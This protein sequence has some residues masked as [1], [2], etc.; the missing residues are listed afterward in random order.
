[1]DTKYCDLIGLNDYFQPAY[2]L[3]NEVQN[4]WKQFIPNAKFFEVL[5]GVLSSCEG[6]QPAEKKSLWL[7]GT[8][9]TGKS[10][11]TSVL[12]HLLF[13]EYTEI[14]P[15]VTTH[16]DDV[17]LK[18][19]LLNFRR[20]NR[21]FPV[22]LKGVSGIADHRTFA[23]VLERAVKHALTHYAI[24][25]STKSDFEK[26]ISK[27]EENPYHSDWDQVIKRYPQLRMYVKDQADLIRK[28]K[29][30]DLKILKIL[31][32]LSSVTGIHFSHANITDWLVEVGTELRQ[33]QRAEMLMLY[34]DEFTSVLELP[35]SGILL[36]ELQHIAELSVHK[37]IYLFM[38]SHR[39]P[40]Q[41]R[42]AKDDLEKVLGR[43]KTL[44]YSM[45][46]IT[47]Y[48]IISASIHKKDRPAWERLRDDQPPVIDQLIRR[49]IGAEGEAR[50]YTLLRNLF[51]IHPYTAY[52]ATFLS[53]N[54]GSTERSIFNFLYDQEKGF[55]RFLHDFPANGQG[56][57]LTA[58]YLWDFFVTEFERI[59]V[60]RFG[61]ILDRYKLHIDRIHQE[62]HHYSVIFKGV[63]LCNVL[64]KMVNVAEAQQTLVAPSLSN[65]KSLFCGTE[66]ETV[67]EPA[68]AFLDQQQIIAKNP[69]DLFVV[70]ASSLPYREVE[71]RK[72]ELQRSI[73]QID[74]ILSKA[75]LEDLQKAFTTSILR[76]TEVKFF[77]AAVNEALLKNKL[78]K[79]Y[80]HLYT[81][82]IAAIIAR[83]LQEREQSKQIIQH[84]LEDTSFQD[85]IFVIFEEILDERVY[86]QFIDYQARA[87]IAGRMNLK[88]EQISNENYAQKVL[89]QWVQTA[90]SGYVEWYVYQQ[91]EAEQ[92]RSTALFDQSKGKILINDFS[93][94]A[95]DVLSERIFSFGIETLLE[96]R[97]NKNVW[98]P[99]MTKIS[100]EN[101]LFAENRKAVEQKTE[102]GL[103]R[104]TRDILKNNLGEYI[105]TEDLQL[106]PDIDDQH[107]LVKMSA[108]IEQAITRKKN[109]TVF[110]LGDTLQFLTA[111]PFGVY[112]NMLYFAALGFLMRNYAGK[113]YEAGKGKP[114][115]KEIMRDKIV[116]LF[117]YWESGKDATKLDVRLGT[118]EEKQLIQDLA[119]LFGLTGIESLND[120]RWGIR[121][122][123]KDSQYPLWVFTRS[124][125]ATP[126]IKTA[127]QQIINLVESRE[128][129]ISQD[130]VRQVLQSVKA[131]ETDLRMFVLKKEQSRDL[132]ITWLRA[133]E[134]VQIPDSQVD[135]VI[136]YIRRNMPEEIGVDSWKEENVCLKVQ[137]WYI[138]FLKAQQPTPPTAPVSLPSNPL[139]PMPSPSGLQT[140]NETPKDRLCRNI[141]RYQGNWREALKKIVLEHEELIAIFE[142]YFHDENGGTSL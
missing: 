45:E 51:P 78:V 87:E 53:R 64:Y 38:V 114:V 107:P 95:S 57:F 129:E 138:E 59:D 131:V 44:D 61:A 102:S 135:P 122:W 136:M 119:N 96:V 48:H 9:G 90:R 127:I 82:H 16:F 19:R 34:W 25:I 108:E 133:I 5:R 99:K 52:L 3:T 21:V 142:C 77:D 117:N 37:G 1:M 7:Q 46:P 8:Y 141:D 140:I 60:Q 47:T 113:L 72:D 42:I 22:V 12:K 116:A 74:K 67:V 40:S 86:N 11:A 97:K 4:Y 76:E 128:D 79:A 123:I 2:D 18:A 130:M 94:F 91:G 112:H 100:A 43:F 28:L 41:A 109:A 56:R 58:D 84:I 126:P 92:Q 134:N 70:A 137:S 103:N 71:K 106:K 111:P 62:N 80:T 55:L 125:H 50:N 13:D 110:N 120:V 69:D 10:H 35:N 20:A 132:F 105:V 139:Y 66:Y 39:T 33:Q 23:L 115:E 118:K 32:E 89:T 101:F 14:E 124:E 98:P 54:I 63:L 81:L 93:E 121:S 27:I 30:E 17:Q 15:F 83:N 29:A 31:E 68:L 36:S 26:M 73:D 49:I 104:Y 65:I 75:H 85:I 6:Q 88:E 24:E